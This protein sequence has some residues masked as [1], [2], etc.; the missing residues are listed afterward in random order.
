RGAAPGWRPGGCGGAG[1]RA[2]R[3]GAAAATG[4]AP[5]S[6][7]DVMGAPYPA[8]L[9]AS[10]DGNGAAW[11]FD[12]RGVR[13]IWVADRTNAA[14]ARRVTSY[15]ADDG[16][17]IGE[18][19]W[20]PDTRQIAF[21]RGQTLE[22]AKPANVDSAPGGPVP[23]EIRIVSTSAGA[24]HKLGSG[25][26]RSFAPDGR[27][28]VWIDGH[29]IMSADPRGDAPAAPLLTDQG[30]VLQTLW[31]PDGRRLAFVSYRDDHALVG[32]Y[33]LQAKT[34]RWMAPSFD[35]DSSPV[36]SPDGSQLAYIHVQTEK[37]SPFVSHPAGLP[38]SIR[39]ADLATGQMRQVWTADAGDGSVFWP[40]L[41]DSNLLWTADNRLIF[42]WEK[43]GWLLP[44]ALDLNGG[45][46]RPL[47]T[48]KLETAY[49]TLAPGG[50]ELVFATNQDDV[51]RL[52]IW[53]VAAAGGTPVPVVPVGTGIEAAPKV[54]NG[55]AVY[56][57]RST[58]TTQLA[59][60]VA[61]GNRWR[62]LAPQAVPATFPASQLVT[63]Q[64][65]TFKDPDGFITHGQLFLP[66][67]GAG[68]HAAILF[69][70]GGPPRQM[71]LGFH[72]MSAYSWMY[73]LNEY[74]AAEGYVVLS[75]NYRGGIGY[76]MRYREAPGFGMGGGSETND[77]RGG[78]D[79]LKNR[80]DVDGSRIG[81]WGGSYGGLMT[82][83]AL[84]RDSDAVK[85]G[86]DYAGVYDWP[87]MMAGVG[88]PIDDPAE[89]KLARDSS[90]VATIADWHSPVLV[91]QADD[92][93]N[94]PPQQSSE[95]I[96]DL[97]THHVPFD[98]IL[99]PNE[100]HDLTR[101]A[102]WLT[103]FRATDDYLAAH[104]HPERTTP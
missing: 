10:P 2:R 96:Q 66:P 62:A 31:S 60:V 45:G 93:R 36:F 98:Q 95:L 87:S 16:Y 69:F 4:H 97:R 63:P 74:L 92:D 25:N 65:V 103:L 54:A 57:L 3:G 15:A 51:D 84:A 88:Q 23:R 12:D 29:Q 44:Y 24:P 78:I 33:D 76:G 91:V 73:A 80:K 27:T 53:K 37:T 40:T 32:V 6:I 59:P 68:R 90:P 102:S 83:L 64:A 35:Q 61:D 58:A 20:S 86:V 94:V 30:A 39:V 79:Y 38:W 11:V 71:L 85:V 81:A 50:R 13:N 49:M 26:T 56:A 82:A 89:R 5:F 14:G 21:T 99:L 70:H 28:L 55:G 42:P 77:I 52:H 48:G 1:R 100:V 18:L 101:Y 34:I 47:A 22:D 75:V 8:S 72:Y 46:V 7:A 41:S 9:I 17:D 43:T 19:A 104:L 67:D